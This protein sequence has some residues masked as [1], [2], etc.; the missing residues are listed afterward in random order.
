MISDRFSTPPDEPV[1][2]EGL[3]LR[4]DWS[5][6]TVTIAATSLGVL[7]VTLIAVL[8]GMA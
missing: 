6:R 8:M 2:Y 3:G 1:A 5:E 7:V 4:A